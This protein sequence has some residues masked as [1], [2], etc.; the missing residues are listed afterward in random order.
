MSDEGGVSDVFGGGVKGGG[1][2][3]GRG[4]SD[5]VERVSEG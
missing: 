1:D 5:V 3:G 4:V 2:V